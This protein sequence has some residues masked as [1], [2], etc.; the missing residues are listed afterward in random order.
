[1]NDTTVGVVE[2]TV[3]DPLCSSVRHQLPWIT[4]LF[5]IG[6]KTS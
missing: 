2:V 4:E 5:L 1:M 6:A 3:L